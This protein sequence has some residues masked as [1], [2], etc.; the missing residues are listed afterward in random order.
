MADSTSYWQ[1]TAPTVPLS[2][3]LPP[4]VDVVVIGGGLM[5]TATSYWLAREGVSVALLEREAIGWGATGRNGGFV[6][7][8]PTESYPETIRHL[9]HETAYAVMTDTLTNQHLMRQVIEEEAIICD[10]RT[11]GTIRLALGV[12][13]EDLLREEVAAYQADGFS[14]SF[15]DR[16]AVQALIKT[17]LSPEI[18]GGRFKH[19]QGLLH[20]ARFV[21]GLAQAA[22]RRGLRAYQAEVQTIIPE[23][24]HLRVQTSRGS[25]QTATVVVAANAWV[26]RLVPELADLILP[27]REQML[28]YAPIAP[29]FEHGIS[30]DITAGEYFQQTADGTILIGGCNTVA[31]G[32]DMGVWEMT[33]L[34]IVQSAIEAVLPRLFPALAPLQVV[35]RW[36]GLLDYTTDHHPIVDNVPTLPG[37]FVVC[38]F[39]GHGMPFGLRF[40]QLLMEAVMSSRLPSALKPYRLDR[41]TLKPWKVV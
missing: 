30:A 1:H 28:A 22:V 20:S 3:D 31:P 2:T 16:Q 32:E 14:V 38:G 10:Y 11:P 4:S 6:V 39:S 40:G 37:V 18:R 36:A 33:P 8:G 35:R 19:G 29:I 12:I 34:P 27:A 24:L 13:E 26:G 25:I 5:G 41:P 15:F 7:A 21:R 9:G 17:A 23:G